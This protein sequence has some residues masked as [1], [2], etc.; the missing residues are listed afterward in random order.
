MPSIMEPTKDGQQNAIITYDSA[1]LN[2]DA[3]F[4]EYDDVLKCPFFIF[5]HAINENEAV[6]LLFDTTEIAGLD[7]DGLYEWYINRKNQN[8]FKC[9]KLQDGVLENYFNND[10]NEFEQWCD[11][12][13]YDFISQNGQ[14]VQANTELNFTKTLSILMGESLVKKY[15][16]YTPF[17][18]EAIRQDLKNK[19]GEKIIYVYGDLKTVLKDHQITSNSTFVFSDVSKIMVL[20]DL[21]LLNLSS[22]LIADKYAY[23]YKDSENLNIDLDE[24]AKRA[25]F[26]L[27]RFNNIDELV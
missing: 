14:L 23:N 1:F 2:C 17:E 4:I 22:I 20:D 15:Y 21:G 5:L 11:T 12:I 10:R 27:D 13:L 26:K 25:C 6:K 18:V 9:L 3:I 19:Y 16:V 24:L 8:I 7:I